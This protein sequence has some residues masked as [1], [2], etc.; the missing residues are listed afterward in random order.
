MRLF[1]LYMPQCARRSS[2][3]LLI[4]ELVITALAPLMLPTHAVTDP[5]TDAFC[6][7]LLCCFI[8]NLLFRFG[9]GASGMKHTGLDFRL[10][11]MMLAWSLL[12]RGFTHYCTHWITS[13]TPQHHH[14]HHHYYAHRF[15]VAIEG[16]LICTQRLLTV[17]KKRVREEGGVRGGKHWDVAIFIAEPK[18]C[19]LCKRLKW[20]I[21]R[22][23]YDARMHEH[24]PMR[25][26]T[27]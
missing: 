24:T 9:A 3:T 15:R 4:W 23:A 22:D 12:A 27:L 20:L 10:M 7:R 21:M 8:K 5:W 13:I 19:A 16:L 26:H 2:G 17:I 25:T 1:A 11:F 18:V 14:H 6:F